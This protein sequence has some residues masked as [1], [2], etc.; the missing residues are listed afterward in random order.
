LENNNPKGPEEGFEKV[1]RGG[2]WFFRARNCRAAA[3]YSEKPTNKSNTIGFRV[4]L[5]D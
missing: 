1:L 5:P 4:V 3:R 2:S